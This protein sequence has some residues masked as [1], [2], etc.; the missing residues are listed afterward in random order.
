MK[1]GAFIEQAEP[2]KGVHNDSYQFQYSFLNSVI[3]E[4]NRQKINNVEQMKQNSH[5]IINN[6]RIL[7]TTTL[8]TQYFK[9][10]E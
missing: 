7:C 9:Q 3:G 4:M 10:H 6:N 2:T 8:N 5:T 1:A